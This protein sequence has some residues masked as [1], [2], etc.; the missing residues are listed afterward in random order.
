MRNFWLLVAIVTGVTA[1]AADWPMPAGGPQRN[2]WAKG[3]RLI[4][5]SNVGRLQ[6]LYKLQAENVSRGLNSLT[7]PIVDGNLITYRGFKEMLIFGASSNRVFSIDADL[8]E[9]IWKSDLAPHESIP[10]QTSVACPGGLTAPVVMAGSSSGSMHFAAQASR[11][12]AAAGVPAATGTL[13]PAAVTPRRSPYFPPLSQTIYPLTPTT[14]TQLAAL[15]AVSSDGYLHVLNS[16]TGED[17]LPAV[18]FLTPNANV[19]SLNIRDNTVYATTG[20]N[21]D[22]HLNSVF[23]LDLLSNPK[24]VTSFAAQGGGFAGA[25][26]IG[27]DGTVYVQAMYAPGDAIGHYHE[28]IVALTPK[29]LTVKDY[30]TPSGGS[31][32]AKAAGAPGITPMVFSYRGSDL[33]VVGGKNGRVYLLDS[34]SLGGSDHHTPL[35][36]SDAIA[37]VGK[38]YDGY[39]FRGTFS[40]WLDTAS[41]TRWFYAPLFGPT[42]S[43][44]KQIASTE[45]P[46]DGSI[47]AL[48]LAE[49]GAKPVLQTAWLSENIESPASPVVANGLLFVLSTGESPRL[50]K[51]NGSPYSVSEWKQM[52]TNAQLMAFDGV[53]G[54]KLYSSDKAVTASSHSGALA[55]ANGR[56]YFSTEDN[57]VYCFGFL[58][59]Q[60]QLREH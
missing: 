47:L 23:A 19:T 13:P 24:K 28:T 44:L 60:S 40:S 27:N 17:L 46:A 30:F 7:A 34:K 33:V 49:E 2:S 3:E 5:I 31:T 32:D 4:D 36:A 51:Q 39:G 35:F 21:C 8:N 29:D 20:N 25:T 43:G 10:A 55:I 37:R 38:K 42:R 41:G 1:W 48:R 56:V 22:G 52:A 58:N 26:A 14:L 12:P 45:K 18:P 54:R 6:L 50:A 53:T 9:P 15:Y 11:A 57:S 16:S 59:G